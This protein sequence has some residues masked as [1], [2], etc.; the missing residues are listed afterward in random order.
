MVVIPPGLSEEEVALQRKFKELKRKKKAL[1]ALKKRSS[2]SSSS[3]SSAASKRTR[4]LPEPPAV[5]AAKATEQARQLV[6]A[7]VVRAVKAEARTSGF[8][9]PRAREGRVRDAEQGLVPTAPLFPGSVSA[10][11]LVQEPPR[12]AQ[13]QPLDGGSVSARDWVRV[14]G[15]DGRATGDTGTE[16]GPPL[17]SCERGPGAPGAAWS[18]VSLPRGRSPERGR[19]R[20]R[21]W[22]WDRDWDQDRHRHREAPVRRSDSV[23]GRRAP[24]KGSTLHV[25]EEDMTPLLLRGASSP[26]GNIIDLSVDPPRTCAVVP[27]EEMETKDQAELPG[28]RAESGPLEGSGA[29]RAK[30]VW[31]ALAARDSP[32]GCHRDRRTQ[33]VYDDDDDVCE[34]NLV[35]G[36]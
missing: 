8:K 27:D 9:R 19:D 35:D 21:E 32:K 29:F 20:G 17:G 22:D 28:T 13:R 18:P 15:P 31:G 10:Q 11:D 6:K 33:R 16:G 30:C 3:S 4:P 23:P 7:G 12:C 2:S 26:F 36:F 5:D 1:L 34:E 14:L 25:S 24:R